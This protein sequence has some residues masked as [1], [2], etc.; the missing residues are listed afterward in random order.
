[1]FETA[2]AGGTASSTSAASSAA[3][4]SAALSADGRASRGHS[5]VGRASPPS[6][7]CGL[8]CL[9]LPSLRIGNRSYNFHLFFVRFPAELGPG[10]RSNGP[11]SQK[12][13]RTQPKLAPETL[14]E[15][16]FLISVWL[17]LGFVVPVGRRRRP[18]D[19]RKSKGNQAEST[20]TPTD[21]GLARPTVGK[22]AAATLELKVEKQLKV[23][24][25]EELKTHTAVMLSEL[26]GRQGYK[27]AQ[28]YTQ[29][30]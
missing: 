17:P 12:W 28:A 29:F 21:T 15:G 27:V 19:R 1:M 30:G 8:V 22:S 3:S 14:S 2:P 24:V 23:L 13:C 6:D 9:S 25:G 4:S 5:V 26:L 7:G 11:G 20:R 16:K 18:Q 10:T